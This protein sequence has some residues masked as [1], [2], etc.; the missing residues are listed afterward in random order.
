MSLEEKTSELGFHFDRVRESTAKVMQSIL[1]NPTLSPEEQVILL[2]TLAE[3]HMAI[4][5]LVKSKLDFGFLT[6]IQEKRL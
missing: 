6:Q 4:G 1:A 5:Q 2:N 3:R